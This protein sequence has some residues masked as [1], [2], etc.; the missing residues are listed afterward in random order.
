MP[1]G[2]FNLLDEPWIPVCWTAGAPAGQPDQVGLRH[3][4]LHSAD[5]AGLSISEPPAHSALLR[6]LYALTARVTGLD[7]AGPG[8]WGERRDDIVAADRLPPEGIESYIDAYRDRFFLHDPGGRPWMQ[9][10]RLAEQ[11]DPDN[12]AGVN[13]LIVTRPA[14]QQPRL[15]PARQRRGA[16][17]AHG[18]RSG[19]Q[20]AGLA[21]LRP[22]RTLLLPRGQ[23]GQ[24]R[25]HDRRAAAYCAVLPP[26]GRHAPAD[27]AGGP[28]P[29]GVH[30]AAH[31]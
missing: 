25:E 14:G 5:I 27:A 4:L 29:P 26:R 13:K 17:S 22:L 16:G 3:L 19:A 15:V 7:E 21:L 8:D 2:T 11:C 30:C 12:T 18:L 31:A 24:K 23:R 9:D 10:P 20:P 28:G 1:N 6:V